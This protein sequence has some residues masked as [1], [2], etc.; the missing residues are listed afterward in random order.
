MSGQSI[1]DNRPWIF[2]PSADNW[3]TL[4]VCFLFELFF[5]GNL[6]DTNFPFNKFNQGMCDNEFIHLRPERNG[7]QFHEFADVFKLFFMYGNCCILIQISH[8]FVPLDPIYNKS[9]LFLVMVWHQ[10][11]N[12]PL[13]EPM[14]TKMFW[15]TYGTLGHNMLKLYEILWPHCLPGK[16]NLFKNDISR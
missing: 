9:S 15:N 3:E 5:S 6:W 4:I 16:V 13:P 2:F 12:E 1:Y 14:L 10:T 11:E 7:Y 8:T